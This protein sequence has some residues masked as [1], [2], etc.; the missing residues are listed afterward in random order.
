MYDDLKK[1]IIRIM[2]LKTPSLNSKEEQYVAMW[3]DEY[4]LKDDIIIEGFKRALSIKGQN[5]TFAYVSAI[6]KNWSDKG[7]KSY[8]DILALDEEFRKRKKEKADKEKKVE[9][10]DKK[11][12]DYLESLRKSV[13]I[14]L[15]SDTAK[16]PT[17]G[18]PFSAG[19][20]LYADIEKDVFIDFGETVFVSSGVAISIPVGYMGLILARSGLSSKHGIAPA[21]KI[22]LIDSDYNGALIVSCHNHEPY[23][24]D[25]ESWEEYVERHTI[26]PGD[27]IAQLVITRYLPIGFEVV[28]ELEET[29][30]G[31]GGFG[32]TGRQ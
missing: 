15:L 28:D 22:G 1:R 23:N 18:T 4:K 31:S 6:L 9:D 7:V 29:K 24:K 8:S 16:V 3:K 12:L 10:G 5:T 13:K 20:D 30:R 11:S 2:E 25:K 17:F 21:N 32:S 26:H 14:K 27:R 19:A